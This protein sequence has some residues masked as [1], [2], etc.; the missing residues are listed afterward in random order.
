MENKIRGGYPHRTATRTPHGKK[1]NKKSRRTSQC[2]AKRYKK[3]TQLQLDRS[4]KQ[5][6]HH[7]TQRCI[8]NFR[9]CANP[10]LSLQ[11]NFHSVIKNGITYHPLQPT[12]LTFHNL[13]KNIRIAHGTRQLLGLHLKYCLASSHVPDNIKPL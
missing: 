12:N 1:R 2:R 8:R 3:Q 5:N 6:Q 9:F 13:C 11:K 7:V 4:F 10:T